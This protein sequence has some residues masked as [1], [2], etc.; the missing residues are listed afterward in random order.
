MIRRC[1]GLNAGTGHS[2][3]GRESQDTTIGFGHYQ[4]GSETGK[5]INRKWDRKVVEYR[6]MWAWAVSGWAKL[7]WVFPVR[8]KYQ[9]DEGW[10]FVLEWAKIQNFGIWNRKWSI[11]PVVKGICGRLAARTADLLIHWLKPT[12]QHTNPNPSNPALDLL[13]FEQRT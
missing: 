3:W 10:I 13:L 9:M 1:N 12:L 5:I 8:A 6:R 2:P 7:G 11:E 4:I